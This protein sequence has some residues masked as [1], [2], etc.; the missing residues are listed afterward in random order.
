[1]ERHGL[2]RPGVLVPSHDVG[3]LSPM[4]FLVGVVDAGDG[5]VTLTRCVQR[6]SAAV[7]YASTVVLA[8]LNRGHIALPPQGGG[9]EAAS[10]RGA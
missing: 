7:S 9:S 5:K 4:A 2:S 3:R 8:A 10:H 6:L 1:M